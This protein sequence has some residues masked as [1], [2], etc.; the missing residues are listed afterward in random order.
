M[1]ALLDLS[2]NELL[3]KLLPFLGYGACYKKQCMVY[4]WISAV[5]MLEFRD[6]KIYVI[7]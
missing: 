7:R 3:R 5:Q 2:T 1:T 6:Q 4:I